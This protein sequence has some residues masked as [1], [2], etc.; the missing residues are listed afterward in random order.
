MAKLILSIGQELHS[1][2]LI[3]RIE[4]VLGQ[5]SFGITYK[6]KA[7]TVIKGKFGEELV[8]TNTP[9]A[10]KE[11]FMKEV[12]DRDAS[13]SITG[14][15]EGSLSYNY[16]QKFKKEAENL[17]SMNHPNIVKVI[18]FISANNTYYYVMDFIE[19]EN[20]ND[21]LKHH[22]MSEEEATDTII[23]VAK[24]LKYMHE[25]KHM[26]HLDL[27]PSNIMRR[28]S[29]GRLFL[30]DFG[31]SKHYN[32]EGAP[33][34]STS[35]GLGTLGYAPIEQANGKNTKQFRTTLDIYAL[36]AT[37]YKLLTGNTPP[38]AD[39][40]VSEDSLIK[41]ELEKYSSNTTITFTIL[42]AMQP[43][44]KERIQD[45]SSF[46]GYLTGET[47]Y[48]DI[49]SNEYEDPKSKIKDTEN[50][51]KESS[52]DKTK[53]TNNTKWL[54]VISCAIL[55]L[56]V[57]SYV[58]IISKRRNFSHNYSPELVKAANDGDEL[59]QYWLG[60]CYNLGRGVS[61][62]YDEAFKWYLKSAEQGL[63]SAQISIANCYS[64][65][66]GVEQD[67]SK[68]L[69]W[70]NKAVSQNNSLAIN[71][72]GNFYLY[73]N[74]V[75]V[76]TLK[77]IEL[78]RKSAEKDCVF[79]MINLGYAYLDGTG[80]KSDTIKA[81]QL[82]ENAEKKKKYSAAKFFSDYY[83]GKYGETH[84][85]SVKCIK[86]LMDKLE[87]EKD[88]TNIRAT[89]CLIADFYELS[90]G[91][92]DNS[93]EAF[94]WYRMVAELGSA[95]GMYWTGMSYIWGSTV[96]KDFQK[97]FYWINKCANLNI[98][99]WKGKSIQEANRQYKNILYTQY[100]VVESQMTL[101]V[102]YYNGNGVSKD[103]GKYIYWL[104][105]AAKNGSNEAQHSLGHLYEEGD[106]QAKKDIKET[107]KWFKIAVE[108]GHGEACL[109]MAFAYFE[110][111]EGY[112]KND[113]EGIKYLELGASRKNPLATFDL[114]IMYF[115]GENGLPV[116]KVKEKQ[117]LAKAQELGYERAGDALKDL[118]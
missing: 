81:I 55:L 47:D 107:Y 88:T 108:N 71:E 25:E 74:G 79:G 105:E 19:G 51:V 27:K 15:S 89:Y 41:D 33:E 117:Y 46:E 80:V 5:G 87:Q 29:D 67:F 13:G 69:F 44:I 90:E 42:K 39:E 110:G 86:M 103:F 65:A 52:T 50:D 21:Y 116:D 98:I 40:L 95:T 34:T 32:E 2:T 100:C 7:F 64:D 61:I 9:K 72:L 111:R 16:A 38:P 104:K 54:I 73:G 36:G 82:F 53:Q 8:E 109:D 48:T 94:K 114:G 30:I 102:M 115:N 97:A 75:K 96:E 10:I 23:E 84:R 99:P 3:Y 43:N 93:K 106:A 101:S 35:V 1:D 66:K 62:N 28:E 91:N 17:A 57:I 112:K 11:F 22:K 24:A 68:A 76:D 18:D 14:M 83:R 70:I 77:A 31:L 6:A 78:Y 118:F 26:L 49:L 12:N 20:L 85:D 92:H 37:F 113:E 56:G 45:V 60:D 63:D 4:S 58:L 59:A